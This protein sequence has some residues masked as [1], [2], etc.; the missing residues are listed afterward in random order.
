LNL[1]KKLTVKNILFANNSLQ[2]GVWAMHLIIPIF[3]NFKTI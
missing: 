1:L 3:A 2:Q